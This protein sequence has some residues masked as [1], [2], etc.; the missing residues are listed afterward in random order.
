MV[1]FQFLPLSWDDGPRSSV[2][3]RHCLPAH[4]PSRRRFGGITPAEDG[5]ALKAGPAEGPRNSSDSV[6][7]LVG[8]GMSG[9]YF[10][11]LIIPRGREKLE[12]YQVLD[13][14]RKKLSHREGGQL[15]GVAQ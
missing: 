3:T 6:N 2:P 12:Y 10:D 5:S 11:D 14:P 7:L 15:D 9:H 4:L 13:V 1:V 8:S